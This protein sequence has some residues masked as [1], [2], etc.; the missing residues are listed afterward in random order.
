MP[1]VFMG[2]EAAVDRPGFNLLPG[3]RCAR[4]GK[5]VRRMGQRGSIKSPMQMLKQWEKYKERCDNR[6]IVVFDH[7]KKTG[8]YDV[9]EIIRSVTYTIEGFAVFLGMTKQNF[10]STYS[11]NPK[12]ELA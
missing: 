7:N 12:F 1:F 11:K 3:G 4:L 5:V 2:V 6:D 10:Y 9:N 8:D